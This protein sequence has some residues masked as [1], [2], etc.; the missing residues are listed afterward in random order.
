MTRPIGATDDATVLNPGASGDSMDETGVSYLN[1]STQVSSTRKRPRV[2]LGSDDG[3]IVSV[4]AIDDA[5][6]LST[7]DATVAGTLQELLLHAQAQTGLLKIIAM[8]LDADLDDDTIMS[9]GELG[10]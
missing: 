2:V 6:A 4:S 9:L 1:V 5:F 8:A 7:V 10:S 3:D